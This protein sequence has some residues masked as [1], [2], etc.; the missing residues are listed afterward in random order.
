[1]STLITGS[2]AKT[3]SIAGQAGPT[4]APLDYAFV[5]TAKRLRTA[6][7]TKVKYEPLLAFAVTLVAFWAIQFAIDHNNGSIFIPFIVG[8]AT[9]ALFFF[10]TIGF[11]TFISIV[12]VFAYSL[13]VGRETRPLS[14]WARGWRIVLSFLVA[15][16]LTAAAFN[17]FCEGLQQFRFVGMQYIT[18]YDNDY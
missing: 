7:A 15:G 1:M 5:Q 17:L 16:C 11:V 10:S 13:T 6:L 8:G 3:S 4:S 18:L 9:A 14:G 12:F 2:S